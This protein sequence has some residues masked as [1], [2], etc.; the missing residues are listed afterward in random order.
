MTVDPSVLV[1]YVVRCGLG[2]L[3]GL[4]NGHRSVNAHWAPREFIGLVDFLDFQYDTGVITR[5][6]VYNQKLST[7][8][9]GMA[10]WRT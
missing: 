10:R 2:A 4:G 6:L 3:C 1:A 5:G 9:K 7:R 8:D